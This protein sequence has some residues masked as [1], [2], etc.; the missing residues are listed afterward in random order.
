MFHVKHTLILLVS[1]YACVIPDGAKRRFGI[2]CRITHDP[3]SAFGR[4]G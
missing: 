4:P 2:V 3:G 1:G